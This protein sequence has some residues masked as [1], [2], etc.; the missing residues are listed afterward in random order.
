MINIQYGCILAR[1]GHSVA[2]VIHLCVCLYVCTCVY[3]CEHKREEGSTFEL[4]G[5]KEIKHCGNKVKLPFDPI[6]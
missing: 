2:S 6:H 5:T 1:L 3:M 4:G